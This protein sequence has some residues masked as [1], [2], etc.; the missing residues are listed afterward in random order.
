M[1]DSLKKMSKVE[2]EEGRFDVMYMDLD[3]T[4]GALYE[5][6]PHFDAFL[7]KIRSSGTGP[8]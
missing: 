1:Y 4:A 5:V 7:K 6:A 3:D 8:G 2:A